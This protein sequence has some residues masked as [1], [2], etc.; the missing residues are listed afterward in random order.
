MGS[1]PLVSEGYFWGDPK[2]LETRYCG[3][4]SFVGA[5]TDEHGALRYFNYVTILSLKGNEYYRVYSIMYRSFRIPLA[6]INSSSPLASY[7]W[8]K[9]LA[10]RISGVAILIRKQLK[11]KVHR[12]LLH[13]RDL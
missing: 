2:F 5:H 7:H 11:D 10:C 12:F 8:N 3:T 6:I 13:R 1:N 4:G 9:N